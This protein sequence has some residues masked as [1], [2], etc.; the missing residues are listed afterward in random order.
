M[1]HASRSTHHASRR[2]VSLVELLISLAIVAALLSATAVAVKASFDAYR[3]NQT[4][5]DLTQRARLTV[6]RLL[7][8]VRTARDHAPV[9]AAKSAQFASG[10]R[11]VDSGVA[12][13]D[14]DGRDVS[15]AFDPADGVI[16]QTTDGE[17]FVL[18][19]G[20]ETFEVT[21]EPMRS[22]ESLK[23]GGGFDRLRRA[24]VLLTLRADPLEGE[25]G[26]ETFTLSSSVVPRANVW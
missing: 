10:Q 13:F 6:H 11:V 23:A 25:A 5:A 20:V 16:R 7:G 4:Q 26:G 9:T 21:L 2:G 8:A 24:T 3:A 14:A 19:R 18:V 1:G 12:M 17:T 22:P 15:F